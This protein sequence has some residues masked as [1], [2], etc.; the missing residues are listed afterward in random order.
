M[1]V[2]LIMPEVQEWNDLCGVLNGVR[3][4]QV[5]D[6]VSWRLEASGIFSIGSLYKEIFQGFCTL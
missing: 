5:R 4:T 2:A 1:V 6:V 3:I